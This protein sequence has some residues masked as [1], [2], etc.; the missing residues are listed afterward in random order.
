MGGAILVIA[1]VGGISDVVERGEL[2]VI[3][4]VCVI[5][6]G[7]FIVHWPEIEI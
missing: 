6:D 2:D 3:M 1:P 7:G 5:G 4:G